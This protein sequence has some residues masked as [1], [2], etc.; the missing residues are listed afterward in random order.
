MAGFQRS[1]K[2]RSSVRDAYSA[3]AEEL[4]ASHPFP[5]GRSF[6]ESLGYPG[7]LLDRM[8]RASVD[9]FAGVSNVPLFANL[10]P[11]MTVLDLGCGAGLDSL[12][13]AERIGPGGRVLGLDF[14]ES[15]LSRARQ[16]RSQSGCENVVFCLGDAERLPLEGRSI[17][18]A[19]INGLFNLNPAR[20]EIFPELMRVL[21]SG[22]AAYVAELILHEPLPPEVRSSEADWF[23]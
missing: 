9:A 1:M 18:T 17:D 15:M 22:G 20:A 12:I 19:L 6:A 13:A 10:R 14:S 7:D 23:A 8:P 21:R 3:A 11:G 4:G 16:A 5:V 2:L